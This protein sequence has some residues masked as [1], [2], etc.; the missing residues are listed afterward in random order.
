VKSVLPRFMF[1]AMVLVPAGLVCGVARAQGQIVSANTQAAPAGLTATAAPS[2][3][4]SFPPTDTSLTAEPP[5]DHRSFRSLAMNDAGNLACYSP[6]DTS[7]ADPVSSRSARHSQPT[8]EPKPRPYYYDQFPRKW[9]LGLAFALVRFRSSIY[10]ASAPGLNSSLAYW[11]KDWVAVEGAVT[12]AFA[13][14]VFENEHFRY[15]GYGAGPKFSL[16]HERLQPWA[17]ALIGGVHL[18]PQTATSGRNGFE[19]TMGGGINYTIYNVLAAK[20]GLDYLGTH[21]FSEWQSS[22][23]VVA[24]FALRF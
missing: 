13:P 1:A 14:P 2:I 23:Q 22:F 4:Q 11:F 9:E 19:V 21:M 5:L 6:L 24:G 20:V 17:H 10:S 3:V 16:G 8:P 15:L 7:S 18:I 12:T